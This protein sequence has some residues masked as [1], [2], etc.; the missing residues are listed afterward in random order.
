MRAITVP[1]I[2]IFLIISFSSA[3]GEN[4]IIT[5]GT[6]FELG[7]MFY[8]QESYPEAIELFKRAI[9]LEEND[10]YHLFLAKS[11]IS[12]AQHSLAI[13]ELKR[14]LK[15]D[16]YNKE[17]KALLGKY[18]SYTI[19]L[20]YYEVSIGSSKEEVKALLNKKFLIKEEY[21]IYPTGTDVFIYEISSNE[22]ATFKFKNNQLYEINADFKNPV[23]FNKIYG[24]PT[25]KYL[26]Y[27]DERQTIWATLW[28]GEIG[29]VLF[30]EI[31]YPLA[32]KSSLSL[33]ITHKNISKEVELTAKR[34][35]SYFWF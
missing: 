16:P 29:Q 28:K 30:K 14:I 31:T 20:K 2:F 19:P 7:L 11:Y 4:G 32:S 6:Y 3:L 17:A 8:A 15:N 18:L 24:F 1:L 13:I 5:V 26:Y 33:T 25:K 12:N 9:G 23:D 22:K 35:H 34:R 10:I 27:E 21:D